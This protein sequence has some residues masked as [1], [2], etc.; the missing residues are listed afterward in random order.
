MPDSQDQ[1][2]YYDLP[3]GK[4]E[5]PF[6]GTKKGQKV[7]YRAMKGVLNK[8]ERDQIG[9]FRYGVKLI[10]G[11]LKGSDYRSNLYAWGDHPDYIGEKSPDDGFE[12]IRKYLHLLTDA[13]KTRRE[14]KGMDYLWVIER[15]KDGYPHFHMLVLGRVVAN[16]AILRVVRNLWVHKYG[17]GNVDIQAIRKGLRAGV[18]YVMKYLT[19]EQM[20]MPKGTRRYGSTQGLLASDSKPD[21]GWTALALVSRRGGSE[22]VIRD[23]NVYYGD[24]KGEPEYD[25]VNFVFPPP[26]EQLSLQF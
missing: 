3:C 2:L 15:Q 22:Q 8:Y 16:R 1:V 13:L 5:C 7:Y 9:G 24:S 12:D 20:V 4:W 21:N 17:L 6:C 18:K 14:F 25:P 19:K 10:T 11:T 23:F 26:H